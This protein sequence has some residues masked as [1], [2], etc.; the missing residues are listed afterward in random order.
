MK[1]LVF[2]CRGQLGAALAESV[3][4]DIEM[5]GFDLPEIDITG[6]DAVLMGCR[7]VNPDVVINAAAY[8]AVDKAESELAAA[9]AVNVEGPRNIALAAQDV[10]AR[11]IHISTDYVFD[12]SSATPYKPDAKT[13]PINVYGLTKRQGELAVLGE[14]SGAAVV[15]RTSWLYSNTGSNF[16]KSMLRLMSERE[17]I[18]VV[19]DQTGSPT[20][21]DALAAAVWAFSRSA[22]HS[23]I[24]HWTDGGQTN[25]REFAVAIQKEALALGIL[26]REISIQAIKTADYPT[27]APRPLYSVLDCSLTHEV[28]NLK[29][30]HWRSN[31]RRMLEGKPE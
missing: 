3:P 27:A 19:A 5:V 25:W 28:L 9:T 8:T 24:F 16:V 26:Q 22:Q 18:S 11:V 13:H 12:G 7:E 31:L 4:D 17:E 30:E 14:T 29:A 23:G 10:G 6:A 1:I 20:W 15:L 2:G 21:S